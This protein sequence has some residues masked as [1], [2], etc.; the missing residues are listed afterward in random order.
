MLRSQRRDRI[1]SIELADIHSSV[2]DP[3]AHSADADLLA[4]IRLLPPD[5]RALLA[6]RYVAR[7]DATKIGRALGLSASGVRTGLSRLVSR[8]RMELLASTV[9]GAGAVLLEVGR[10]VIGPS[11]DIE[12]QS[13]RTD[14]PD[15]FAGQTAILADLCAALGG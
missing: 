11:G 10:V 14:L 2:A 6:M 13:G 9:P 15:Y 1:T 4:A 8:I 3:G 5:D 7:F 12:S